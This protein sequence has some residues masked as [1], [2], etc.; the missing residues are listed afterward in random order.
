MAAQN[1]V[2]VSGMTIR[3]ATR[4]TASI[5]PRVTM[6]VATTASGSMW[7]GNRICFTSVGWAKR[8]EADICTADWKKTQVTRP[9]R[10]KRG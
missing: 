8:L 9:E 4:T 7:R 2:L 5:V 6:F 10:M 1:V 3:F